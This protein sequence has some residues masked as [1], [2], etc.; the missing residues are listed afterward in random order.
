MSKKRITVRNVSKSFTE[1]TRSRVRFIHAVLNKVRGVPARKTQ[2]LHD[3]S[4]EA[5]AGENIGIIG[6]NGEGKSTLL[7]IIAGIY[8]PD[9]GAVHCDGG[10][11]YLT[12]FNQGLQD[13]LTTRENIFYVGTLMGLSKKEI[14]SRFDEIVG[15]SGLE[16]YLDHTIGAFS[17]GMM[18]RLSFS[19]GVFCIE[20]KNPDILL[21]DEIGFGGG[22]A[23]LEFKERSKDTVRV[24]L[25][26]GSTVLLVSHDLRTIETYC[27]RVF[28]IDNGTITQIG[29]PKEVCD[30]YRAQHR[31]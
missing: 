1:R 24:F 12:G 17:S 6:R 25:E 10:I 14:Q 7:R 29:D 11:T 15:F 31:A 20:H 4:F 13:D 23:D 26:R 30:A 8:T 3:I 18:A 22:G 2:V 19:I 27:D 28:W 21:I 9:A 16:E 5:F